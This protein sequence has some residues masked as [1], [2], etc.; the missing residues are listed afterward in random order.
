MA[1]VALGRKMLI[2]AWTMLMRGEPYREDYR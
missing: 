2:I 1:R